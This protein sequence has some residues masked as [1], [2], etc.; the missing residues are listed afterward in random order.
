MNYPS[1]GLSVESSSGTP[2]PNKSWGSGGAIIG[3]KGG[4]SSDGKDGGASSDGKD[5]GASN[6]GIVAGASTVGGSAGECSS[7]VGL[8]D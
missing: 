4:A 3:L 5:G 7:E 1:V 2:S 6:E 8:S